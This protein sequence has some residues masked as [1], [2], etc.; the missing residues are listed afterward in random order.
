M[1]LVVDNLLL[2]VFHFPT[3]AEHSFFFKTKSS[4]V[5]WTPLCLTGITIIYHP[6]FYLLYVWVMLNCFH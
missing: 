4:I 2:L 1:D 5:N 3:D 6:M